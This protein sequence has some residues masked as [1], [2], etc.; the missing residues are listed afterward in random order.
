MQG[1]AFASA[2]GSSDGAA[3]FLLHLVDVGNALFHLVPLWPLGAA[4]AWVAWR[5]RGNGKKRAGGPPLA[6][7]GGLVVA[8]ALLPLVLTRA[9]QGAARDW[10]IYAIS[11]VLVAFLVSLLWARLG[12]HGVPAR[13]WSASASLAVALALA[14]WTAWAHEP[15]QQRRIEGLVSGHPAWNA[16]Q[17]A[18]CYDFLG[19]W[20]FRMHRYPAAARYM[21]KAVAAAPNPRYLYQAGLAHWRSGNLEQARLHAERAGLGAPGKAAP[22]WLRAAVARASG[23]LDAAAAYQDSARA[24][25]SVRPPPEL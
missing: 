22:W 11:G 5:D 23:D 21:D 6:L 9:P 15:S 4:A 7:L 24:R 17:R 14:Q 25:G 20:A 3:T 16:E 2:L 8:P 13:I 1:S 18:R 12:A 10:D 19:A